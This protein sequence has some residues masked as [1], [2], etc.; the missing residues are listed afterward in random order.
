MFVAI[1]IISVEPA[2]VSTMDF[3]FFNLCEVNQ[4]TL[5][6]FNRDAGV[7]APALIGLDPRLRPM[8][9]LFRSQ[10]SNNDETKPGIYS[11]PGSLI[12]DAT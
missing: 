8:Q 2:A 4:S 10:T 3:H 5:H 9:Q 12:S 6:F 11:G 1:F 7:S